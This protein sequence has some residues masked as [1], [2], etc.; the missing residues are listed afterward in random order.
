[1]CTTTDGIVHVSTIKSGDNQQQR[2]TSPPNPTPPSTVE[3]SYFN[4]YNC[5]IFKRLA[6]EIP[7]GSAAETI[8]YVYGTD[9]SKVLTRF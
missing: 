7:G 8:G 4:V 2:K 9:T 5:T 1:M 3:L 6:R